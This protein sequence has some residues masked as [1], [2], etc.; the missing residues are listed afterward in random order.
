MQLNKAIAEKTCASYHCAISLGTFEGSGFFDL[1]T[2]QKKTLKRLKPNFSR[3]LRTC[4]SVRLSPP[5]PALCRRPIPPIWTPRPSLNSMKMERGGALPRF[6]TPAG[7]LL[8]SG[9]PRLR[10]PTPRASSP[11]RVA[12]RPAARLRRPPPRRPRGLH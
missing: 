10:P 8:G 7:A 6:A 12:V 11:P 5:A 2:Y 4:L 3:Q 9:P 1:C